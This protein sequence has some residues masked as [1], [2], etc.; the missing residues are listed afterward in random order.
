VQ[1]EAN[2]DTDDQN[3]SII[4]PIIGVIIGALYFFI[5][6]R[7]VIG[8]SI[9][10]EETN[11]WIYNPNDDDFLKQI[12]NFPSDYMRANPVISKKAWNEWLV[13]VESNP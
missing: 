1:Y 6:F 4:A 13:S 11:E 7:K 8:K 9:S 10:A 2:K 3:K 12:P 5:P